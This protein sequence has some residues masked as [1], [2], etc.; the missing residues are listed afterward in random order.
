MSRPHIPRRPSSGGKVFKGVL[1]AR[2]YAMPQVTSRDWAEIPPRQVRLDDLIT[3]K[4]E[5]RLDVLLGSGCVDARTFT[6]VIWSMS[7]GSIS[8]F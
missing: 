8:L 5:L 1:D 6:S 2:P 7:R 4:A 3:V